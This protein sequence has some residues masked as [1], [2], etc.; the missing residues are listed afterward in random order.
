M[1]RYNAAVDWWSY[2]VLLYEMLVGQSPFQGEDEEGL[3]RSIREDVP[4]FPRYV[5]S[6]AKSCISKVTFVTF[7]KLLHNTH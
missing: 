3:F 7:I 5:Q 1:Q 2:G 6:A 4:F